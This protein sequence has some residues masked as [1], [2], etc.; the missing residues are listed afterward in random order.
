MGRSDTAI[1][2]VEL[3]LTLD[4]LLNHTDKKHPA[5]QLDIC[6]YA[7]TQYG[8]KFDE[9]KQAGNEVRRDRIGECLKF[10]WTV[11]DKF[12]DK[13]PFTIE[14][15]KAGKYYMA[16]KTHLDEEGVIQILSAVKND[17]YIEGED[18]KRLSHL[19]LCALTNEENHDRLTKEAEK[20]SANPW[21]YDRSMTRKLN[22]LKRAQKEGKTILI[23]RELFRKIGPN[24]QS[25]YDVRCRVYKIM[26]FGG[27]P[28]AFLI[29]VSEARFKPSKG[30]YFEPIAVIN[31]PD[32]S[33]ILCEDDERDLDELVRQRWKLTPHYN[34]QSIDSLIQTNKKPIEGF[35]IKVSFYFHEVS[36]PY[37][38]S[39]F[40]DFF[41]R[42]LPYTRC[43]SFQRVD[44]SKVTRKN[45][46]Y[47]LAPHPQK[48]GDW[49]VV[50]TMVDRSAF[51]SWLLSDMI[52]EGRAHTIDTIKLVGP[53]FLKRE[54][55]KF[56]LKHAK[57]YANGLSFEDR[58]LVESWISRR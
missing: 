34:G 4:Y 52:G 10:L 7:A 56:Y 45:D 47:Y 18:A 11:S 42:K 3:L 20:R 9:E 8:L 29:P 14:R 37:V 36:R 26:E 15:T 2:N 43:S 55:Y 54:I 40:E 46:K 16:Q 30:F 19:L 38:Q 5:K 24:H 12:Q 17:K 28:Y 49:Y 31:I 44:E 1:H 57:R 53:S 39:S 50:N 35:T 32:V 41:S 51:L 27:Q 58:T 23:R 33:N 25:Y 21:K 6:R 22:L 13:V 48:E